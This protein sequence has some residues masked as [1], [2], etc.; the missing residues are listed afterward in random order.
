MVIVRKMNKRIYAMYVRMFVLLL[1]VLPLIAGNVLAEQ[2][3]VLKLSKIDDIITFSSVNLVEGSYVQP[4]L[5]SDYT[6]DLIEDSGNVLVSSA[7]TVPGYGPFAVTIPYDERCIRISVKKSSAEILSIP[8]Q[9][10]SNYCGNLVCDPQESFEDCEKDCSS[11]S[12]DD[13]C[14]RESD[15][16]CDP[17]CGYGTDP[18]CE[19]GL[20]AEDISIDKEDIKDSPP[21]IET[22][23]SIS[24][25]SDDQKNKLEDTEKEKYPNRES[26][27]LDFYGSNLMIMILVII[28]VFVSSG[29]F[30]FAHVS[31]RKAKIRK[32]RDYYYY[33]LRRGYTVQQLTQALYKEGYTQKEVQLGYNLL[34][35]GIH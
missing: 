2:V 25:G 22:K 29:I 35:S 31:I 23:D 8:V 12:L 10:F 20:I 28:S 1:L 9:E 17:D 30:F 3:Y 5:G 33:Y 27:G 6:A 24:S 16:I 4:S 34:N 15:S 21:P 11:G 14:D 7:F 13:Y 26:L 18:D 32:I 19:G